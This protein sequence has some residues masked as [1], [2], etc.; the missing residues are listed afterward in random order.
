[1]AAHQEMNVI[2]AELWNETV[3]ATREAF[4]R[5]DLLANIAGVVAMDGPDTVVGLTEER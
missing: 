1:M 5:I 4:G 2:D 3:I